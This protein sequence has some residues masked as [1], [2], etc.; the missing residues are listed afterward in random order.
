MEAPSATLPFARD[1]NTRYQSVQGVG[2]SISRPMRISALSPKNSRPS[3][4]AN[5]GVQTK[6][7]RVAVRVNLT[8]LKASLSFCPSTDRNTKNSS[9]IRKGST[10]P[11][12]TPPKPVDGPSRSPTSA[13]PIMNSDCNF[14]IRSKCSPNY[15][16]TSVMPY[17]PYSFSRC[18]N[19]KRLSWRCP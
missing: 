10:R 7:T 1:V 12:D 16:T 5:T 19:T 3:K 15:S 8:F 2:G 6:L 18:N 11:A 14:V 13:A 4:N 17:A 9:A